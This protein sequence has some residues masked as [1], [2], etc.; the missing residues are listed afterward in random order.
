MFWNILRPSSSDSAAVALL[1][2]GLSLMLFFDATGCSLV[3]SRERLYC[4][5]E[6]DRILDPERQ[7]VHFSHTCTL[8]IDSSEYPV[9]DLR[10][11]IKGGPS[12]RGVNRIIILD[13][14]L[15]LVQE[16]SYTSQRPLFCVANNLYV[17]GDLELGNNL[18]E[19]N[20][21]IFT[22]KGKEVTL[23]HVEANEYPIPITRD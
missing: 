22:N 6:A 15:R 1:L 11:L 13:S 21:L 17:Y 23:S 5:L 8:Q 19:G 18:P 9:V 3:D 16:I 12:P 20:L 14:G 10:E 4:A 7:L 2:L